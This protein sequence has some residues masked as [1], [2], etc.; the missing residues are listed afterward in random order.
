M[1]VN[2]NK[3]IVI[4]LV[5]DRENDFSFR[6]KIENAFQILNR[7]Y[8]IFRLVR[9]LIFRRYRRYNFFS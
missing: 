6:N 8:L 3:I 9:L 7:Y 5:A 4:V 2:Y 1:N